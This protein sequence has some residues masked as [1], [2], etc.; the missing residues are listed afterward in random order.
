MDMSKKICT[1]LQKILKKL[2]VLKIIQTFKLEIC[3]CPLQ[4]IPLANLVEIDSV[5]KKCLKK[6]VTKPKKTEIRNVISELVKRKNMNYFSPN[7]PSDDNKNLKGGKEEIKFGPEVNSCSSVIE[8]ES[9]S[10]MIKKEIYVRDINLEGTLSTEVKKYSC[11]VCGTKFYDIQKW[12]LHLREHKAILPKNYQFSEIF[13][14]GF[15]KKSICDEVSKLSKFQSSLSKINEPAENY[16]S[17]KN[18]T[19]AIEN[20][21]I[22]LK[23]R[24]SFKSCDKFFCICGKVF[25]LLKTLRKHQSIK[26]SVD[27]KEYCCDVCRKTFLE[28][29]KLN[30]HMLSHRSSQYHCSECH[31]PFARSDALK[32]H[33]MI[34]H[35]EKKEF[36]CTFC[37]KKFKLKY[38][39]DVHEKNLHVSF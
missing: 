37:Q 39:R 30:R 3:F 6:I 27:R 28:L 32:R 13:L 15:R 12:R 11:E 35:S 18:Q 9:V 33:V 34:T 21:E 1:K 10:D 36:E 8:A 2:K 5:L 25:R 14:K 38:N 16:D 20:N 23:S 31:K 22:D 24:K 7:N 29:G 4:S 19:E 17:F 26:H